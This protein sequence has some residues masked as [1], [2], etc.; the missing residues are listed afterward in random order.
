MNDDA[1]D[2][3]EPYRSYVRTLARRRFW[4]KEDTLDDIVQEVAL[5]YLLHADQIRNRA[6]LKTWI[7]ATTRSKC[8]DH[9]RREQR[10]AATRD[11]L[12]LSM[13]L[14][15]SHVS[16]RDSDYADNPT[17]R[18]RARVGIAEGVVDPDH[19]V[20]AGER[21]AAVRE[22]VAR[23]PPKMRAAMCDELA[24]RSVS[25]RDSSTH[26]TRMHRARRAMRPILIRDPRVGRRQET[27]DD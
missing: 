25:I 24:G 10:L 11:A 1:L 16:I 15:A 14:Q 6:H 13:P 21:L 3:F 27:D 19:C 17:W 20:E 23:L 22:A 18:D 2:G 5:A 7:H 4:V 8:F 26:R 12:Y 9:H